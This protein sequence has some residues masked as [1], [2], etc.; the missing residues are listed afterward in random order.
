MRRVYRHDRC[1]TI[2]QNL[3]KTVIEDEILKTILALSGLL[4]VEWRCTWIHEYRGAHQIFQRHLNKEWVAPRWTVSRS[5]QHFQTTDKIFS[6]F[7]I[8]LHGISQGSTL[9]CADISLEGGAKGA[10]GSAK[11]QKSVSIVPTWIG[12]GYCATSGSIPDVWCFKEMW[13]DGCNVTIFDSTSVSR[14]L[15]VG[16]WKRRWASLRSLGADICRPVWY[17]VC[18]SLLQSRSSLQFAVTSGTR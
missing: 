4:S 13:S 6:C 2:C 12:I 17:V 8:G 18:T 16:D 14:D 11:A 3:L 9:L 15:D 10:C 1:L 5:G 7:P